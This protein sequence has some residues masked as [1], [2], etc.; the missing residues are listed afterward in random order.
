LLLAR[1]TESFKAG[2]FKLNTAPAP[3]KEGEH[4]NGRHEQQAFYGT[5]HIMHPANGPK[6]RYFS[7]YS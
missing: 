2:A 4:G 6:L 1:Q 7:E 3:A 5:G